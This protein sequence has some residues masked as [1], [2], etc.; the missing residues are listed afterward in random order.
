[1]PSQAILP[2]AHIELA[3]NLGDR[4][5]LLGRRSQ[6]RNPRVELSAYWN[7]P[8]RCVAARA[9][10]ILESAYIQLERRISWAFLPGGERGRH[11]TDNG[12][13]VQEVQFPADAQSIVLRCS[14]SQIAGSARN[15]KG[16]TAQLRH[17]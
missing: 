15:R 5:K 4:V 16:M 12:R 11:A 10:V 8:S 9:F 3:I 7:A 2:D 6:A 14:I 1:M 17:A 13:F